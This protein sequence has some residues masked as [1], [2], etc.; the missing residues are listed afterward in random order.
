MVVTWV[1]NRMTAKCPEENCIH[2]FIMEQKITTDPKTG[3]QH[4]GYE[5]IKNN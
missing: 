2:E 5:I 1:G 4:I 3:R